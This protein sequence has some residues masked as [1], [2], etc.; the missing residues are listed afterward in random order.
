MINFV[1]KV[2]DKNNDAITFS[3]PRVF[4]FPDIIKIKIMIIET[5]LIDSKKFRRIRNYLPKSNLY[6]RV[7]QSVYRKV[8]WVLVK[9]SCFQQNS[10][11]ASRESIK[12]NNCGICITD[13]REAFFAP[14]P[15]REQPQ[16]AHP[17]K[18]FCQKLQN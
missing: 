16:K 5:I 13:F 17:E 12:F 9:K 3:R 7:I 8:W 4:I 18:R 10:R 14:P 1:G 6:V 11:S 15:I 2:M